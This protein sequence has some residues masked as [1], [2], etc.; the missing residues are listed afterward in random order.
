MG[1]PIG[2]PMAR[3][4]GVGRPLTGLPTWANVDPNGPHKRSEQLG[5]LENMSGEIKETS[6]TLPVK[7]RKG[8]GRDAHTTVTLSNGLVNASAPTLAEAKQ[9]LVENVL[10]TITSATMAPTFVVND[11]GALLVFLPSLGGTDEWRLDLIAG[12]ARCVSY[13]EG[14]P[15]DAAASIVTHH[16]GAAKLTA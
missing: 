8:F 14:T 11:D 5:R 2:A 13:R 4:I 12:T 10:S 9:K 16:H 7:A 6:I 3:K 1:R 15:E